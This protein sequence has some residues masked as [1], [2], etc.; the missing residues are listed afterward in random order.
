MFEC[1]VMQISQ[2]HMG[3]AKGGEIFATN[4]NKI[5]YRINIILLY[6]SEDGIY[7]KYKANIRQTGFEMNMLEELD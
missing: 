3:K 4:K 2:G 1:I 7:I 6:Q 5:N